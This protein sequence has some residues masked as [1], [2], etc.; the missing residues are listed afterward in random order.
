MILPVMITTLF[1]CFLGPSKMYRLTT[2]TFTLI[3]SEK[4]HPID[5]IC[6]SSYK[7]F[8]IQQ[9]CIQTYVYRVRK[10]AGMFLDMHRAWLE[11]LLNVAFWNQVLRAV[12]LEE[13]SMCGVNGTKPSPTQWLVWCQSLSKAKE[14][15]SGI[16]SRHFCFFGCIQWSFQLSF[17]LTN[18]RIFS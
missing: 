12:N 2:D 6:L 17:F 11:E 4:S 13:F 15:I 7:S 9:V 5:W 16:Y 14:I 10:S 3:C 18:R 8:H 1:K